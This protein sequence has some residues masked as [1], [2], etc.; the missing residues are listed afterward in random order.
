MKLGVVIRCSSMESQYRKGTLDGAD[1][2]ALEQEAMLLLV[3][4]MSG[5]LAGVLHVIIDYLTTRKQFDEYIGSY[6]SLKHP[7]VQILLSRSVSF[8]PIPRS[9]GN[10]RR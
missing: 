6:Q 5:G 3:A 4:E 1:F 2:A 7:S 9:H 8:A 10:G